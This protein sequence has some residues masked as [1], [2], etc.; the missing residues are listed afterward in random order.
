MATITYAHV[1]GDTVYH[2]SEDSGVRKG[3]VKTVEI[4]LRVGL[5]TIEYTVQMS[6]ARDGLID[7]IEADLFADVDAALS[8]YKT[9][10]VI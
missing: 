2:V 9:T 4:A 5:E 7:A 3:V 8:Y 1:P 6:D 10:H